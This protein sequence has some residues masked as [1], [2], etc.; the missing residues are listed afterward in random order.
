MPPTPCETCPPGSPGGSSSQ[1]RAV[2]TSASNECKWPLWRACA[3]AGLRRVGW[4]ELR[5]TV[6]SQLV[7]RGVP[8][9]A[10][11]ELL[12]HASIEM[13]MRYAHLSPD[14]RRD[15]VRVLHGH[16]GQDTGGAQSE[17]ETAKK[18]A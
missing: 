6:A 7:M 11:Q 15:A 13:T 1:S 14:A 3:R 9:N 4:H 18:K 10:V 5:H 17:A 2:D 16:S 8:L 12:G